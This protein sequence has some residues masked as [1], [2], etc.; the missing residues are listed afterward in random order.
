MCRGFKYF[1]I[2]SAGL[3]FIVNYRPIIVTTKI[4]LIDQVSPAKAVTMINYFI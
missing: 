1:I 4:D 3:Y 2:N